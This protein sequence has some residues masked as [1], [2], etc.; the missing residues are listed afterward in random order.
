ML[1]S[2]HGV[3]NSDVECR[4]IARYAGP[5]GEWRARLMADRELGEL[6]RA[7]VD[8]H[9]ARIAQ[10]RAD[11]VMAALIAAVAGPASGGVA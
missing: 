4:A 11:P 10:L 7:A 5:V 1:N 6:H 2:K 3:N 9:R 8:W